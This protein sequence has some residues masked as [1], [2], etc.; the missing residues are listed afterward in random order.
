MVVVTQVS[1]GTQL[2]AQR[3]LIEL[4]EN[5]LNLGGYGVGPAGAA[6]IAEFMRKSD[7]LIAADLTANRLADVGVAKLCEAL[8]AG[9]VLTSLNISQN[10]IGLTSEGPQAIAEAL[11]C[12]ACQLVP[13]SYRCS[14][15]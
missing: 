13:C 14:V 8:K 15:M 10:K 11:V 5:K 7:E 9:S 2:S 12:E 4:D 1:S 3:R 6:T